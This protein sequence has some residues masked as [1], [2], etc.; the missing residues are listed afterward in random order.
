MTKVKIC[1]I[2]DITHAVAAVQAGA[3]FIGL[4]F[5][6]SSPR[7]V[8]L[9]EAKRIIS[10]L[11][12][13]RGCG[14]KLRTVAVFANQ[15]LEMVRTIARECDVDAVQLSGNESLAYC[16]EVGGFLI[17]AIHVNNDMV[18]DKAIMIVREAI[19]EISSRGYLP[20]LDSYRHGVMGGSGQIFDW[21]IARELAQDYAFLLA[22]GLSPENVGQAVSTVLPWGVDVA[23]GV[24]TEGDKDIVKIN[25]F[26][27]NVQAVASLDYEDS[28][29][30]R[31]PS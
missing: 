8:N 21:T 31:C 28:M 26:L 3:D 19:A 2:R 7:N 13:M 14:A 23:S 11:R 22:G 5:V 27:K 15:P 1:G 9:D 10:R 4:N 29:Q 17:K 25:T 12:S 6:P 18:R 24:E 16:S 20:L 30:E